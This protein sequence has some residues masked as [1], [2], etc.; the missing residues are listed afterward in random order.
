MLTPPNRLV[1]LADLDIVALP[2]DLLHDGDDHAAG[3]APGSPEVQQNG[4]VGI[5]HFTLDVVLIDIDSGHI[6]ILLLVS[7]WLYHSQIPAAFP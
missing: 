1:H 2:G 5:H 7:L 6:Q 3:T 4:L